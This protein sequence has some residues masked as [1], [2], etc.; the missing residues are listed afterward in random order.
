[1]ERTKSRTVKLEDLAREAN[2][3]TSTVS[4]ALSGDPSVNTDTRKRI[5][6]IAKAQQYEAPPR[7][8]R[9]TVR[10][11]GA[12][13]TVVMAPPLIDT[14]QSIDPFSLSLLG[15]IIG[16]MR[17]RELNLSISHAVPTD[18]RSV[19]QFIEQNPSDGFI[20]LG[21]SQLHA[22]LNRLARDSRRFVVWG[23]AVEDQ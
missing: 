17:E 4:R 21:Q 11:T 12:L 5:L 22:A 23:A 19:V 20:F 6:Q 18:Q 2:V 8:A 13:I 14:Y 3:S 7:R 1:M 15:G 16:A 9:S 10:T